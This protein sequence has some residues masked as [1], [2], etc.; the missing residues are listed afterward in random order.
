MKARQHRAAKQVLRLQGLL[1]TL[2]REGRAV[3]LWLDW[4]GERCL[5]LEIAKIVLAS[6][7]KSMLAG[8]ECR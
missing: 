8:A 6:E 7:F 1:K 2:L 4:I 5:R 3:W